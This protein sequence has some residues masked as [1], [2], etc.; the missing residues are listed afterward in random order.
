MIEPDMI[1]LAI[2][3]VVLYILLMAINYK[4]FAKYPERYLELNPSGAGILKRRG[5]VYFVAYKLM[6]LLAC[7]LVFIPFSLFFPPRISY[8]WLGF[9][10]GFT[11]FNLY[12]DYLIYKL[13]SK[14]K[15]NV[16]LL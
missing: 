6:A 14:Q 2:I 11:W 12:H 10:L 8:I 15:V 7:I 5:P 9:F 3:I 13:A 16:V 4:G 1:T